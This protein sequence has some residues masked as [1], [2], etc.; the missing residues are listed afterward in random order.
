MSKA[1]TEYRSSGKPIEMKRMLKRVIAFLPYYMFKL[2]QR[3]YFYFHYERLREIYEISPTFRFAGR[4]IEIYGNG[5][6][7]GGAGSYI[8][9]YSSIQTFDECKVS[10]G[11]DCAISHN[12]RI[13]SQS[14]V[15]DQ[16]FSGPRAVKTGNVIIGDNVWI[17]ANVFIGPGI[18][19]GD[20]SI[21]GA[22]SVVIHDVEP[23]TIVA[24]CPARLVK[25]KAGINAK[26]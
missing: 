11:Q 24:G 7:I 16:D 12:V 3:A 17:G 14:Y 21:I 18:T 13:Y 19:I 6:F 15:S 9:N 20:N 23:F 8:G 1:N 25:R 26:E 2:M 10:I 4:Y 22:N 5:R